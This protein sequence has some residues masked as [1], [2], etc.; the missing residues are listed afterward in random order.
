MDDLHL[1]KYDTYA[2]EHNDDCDKVFSDQTY[3]YK[4]LADS[5]KAHHI[6][7]CYIRHVYGYGKMLQHLFKYKTQIILSYS[8]FGRD[9]S[10][11]LYQC[12]GTLID[13]Q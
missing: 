12:S 11:F 13:K 6:A 7:L 10:L 8:P 5:N 3:L 9:Y 1:Y 4:H 2:T